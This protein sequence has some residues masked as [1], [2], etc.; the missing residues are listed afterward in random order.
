M[1]DRGR[2]GALQRLPRDAVWASSPCVG[3]CS[4][5]GGG[6]EER[7]RVG[8]RWRWKGKSGRHAEGGAG[9][10]LGALLAVVMGATRYTR[11]RMYSAKM[12]SRYPAKIDHS[13]RYEFGEDI[14]VWHN[15][16]RRITL[17]VFLQRPPIWR[18]CVGEDFCDG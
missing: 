13:G 14:G 1:A 7:N 12:H 3:A 15:D 18:Q 9:G 5:A 11:Y 6:A 17:P 2:L 10:R 4:S 16:L 8:W